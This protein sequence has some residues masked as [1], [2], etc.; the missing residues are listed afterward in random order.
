[1]EKTRHGKGTRNK[2]NSRNYWKLATWN[3]RGLS[4]K[5]NELIE[6]CQKINVDILGITETK[7]KGQG[8]IE[9]GN[10]YYLIYSGV[11]TNERAKAGVGCLI[12]EKWR[13]KILGWTY[14]S[15][16]IIK[17]E[18]KNGGNPITIIITYGPNEDEKTEEKDKFWEEM[19]LAV[20]K[21]NG[22]VFVIG[23]LNGRVGKKDN[24]T[25]EV[26]GNH[27]EN[28]RNGNGRR[29]I[30]YCIE[31]DLIIAN[32]F[33]THKE[34]NKITR[35]VQ[36]RAEKSIID[37]IIVERN[38]RTMIK[39]AKVQRGPEIYSDHYMLV[40]K[41]ADGTKQDTEKRAK[42][43]SK[44]CHE[45][46]KTYKLQ[47]KEQAEKYK[48]YVEQK[49]EQTKEEQEQMGIEEAWQTFKTILQEGARKVCGTV[50]INKNKK[51]TAWWNEEIKKQIKKK[52]TK[53]EIYLNTR[54]RESYMS[55][56]R[57]REVVK[58]LVIEAKKKSWEDFGRKMEKNKNENQ[59]LFYRV[60]KNLKTA[61]QE[62]PIINSIKTKEGEVLTEEHKIM[63][64]WKE[65]F[66]ELL[67]PTKTNRESTG[68]TVKEGRKNKTE[69]NNERNRENE[70]TLTEIQEAIKS[71]KNG[72]A[73]GHDGITAEMI[74]HLGGNGTQILLKIFRKAWAEGKIP[75]DWEIGVLIPIY[76]KGDRLD[77]NNYRGTTLLSVV[78]KT[79]ERI[80]EK[81]LRREI[82]EQMT[83]SQSGF[84]KGHSI[85]DHIFTIKESIYKTIQKNSELYLGFID[86]EKAFD[87]IPRGKVWECLEKKGIDPQLITATKSLYQ[88]SRNYVRSKNNRSKEF[89]TVDGLRQGGVL[90]PLLF[91]IMMDEI[92][93]KTKEKV[94]QVK[95]GHYKLTTVKISECAFADDVVV[96]GS[97][98]KELQENLNT[99]NKV[100]KEQQM[101]I[102][103]A[104]TKIMVITK[105]EKNVD[106]EIEDTKIE[107]VN[108]FKYLG[109][110]IN[111]KGKQDTEINQRISAATK[112][113]HS[114]GKTFI[115]KNE[116]SRK[117]KMTVY[118]TI[119]RPVLTFGSESWVITKRQKNRIQAVEMK[120]HRRALGITKR[121]HKRNDDIR[122]E[123]GIEPVTTTI[124]KNQLKWY[125]HLTRMADTR[126][127][128]RI[129]DARIN[130]KR[131][132]GRPPESWNGTVAKVMETRGLNWREA[133]KIAQDKRSW[134][135]FVHS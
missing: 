99:W 121:D 31:N 115:G 123:L 91:I 46:T 44:S 85:Q 47:E 65:H 22:T 56:K 16:R 125:G 98:E 18:A 19:N 61:K 7:K 17:V 104:K 51:Q 135:G 88:N 4:G 110:T 97:T 35:E 54:T 128:R 133:R 105:D 96:F 9:V 127:V 72:K 90:S 64:R 49:I 14:I 107:Q 84:R 103:I 129:W 5:E 12:N 24:T 33:Y 57:Q 21:S 89:I 126:Q 15:E 122:E 38:K 27:G 113:Y 134:S 70:I 50:V 2:D 94:K 28:I 1:M 69:I 117:T 131:G 23:D 59:K 120:Y 25:M 37:Y 6:E 77:C 62:Q 76:K 26:I 114:L 41:I 45:A 112:L 93:K 119:F 86:L 87:R 52:K 53:W 74:K 92:I 80:L 71:I 75:H 102:N 20:E 60:L 118:Q 83:D 42:N 106:I 101:K 39:D 79:Y 68:K 40:A 3:I 81:R 95:I 10:G 66:E 55:Y 78:A 130:T 109:V 34:I 13:K 43:K 108:E 32:T 67:N 82:E 100:L 116:I 132:R 111:N 8:S 30:E 36:S 73:A 48:E 11:P 58:N 29:L 63:E 124:E